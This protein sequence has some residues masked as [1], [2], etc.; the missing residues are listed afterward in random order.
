MSRICLLC[1]IAFGLSV[2]PAWAAKT[3]VVVL[4]NGDRITGEVKELAY[5]QL[6]FKTDDIGTLYIEWNKIAALTTTQLLQVELAD[7]RRMFG[8]APEAG[9]APAALRLRSSTASGAAPRAPTDVKMSDIVRIA[10]LEQGVW[11]QRLD[12]SAS[13]GYSFTQANAIQVFN[14]AADVGSRDRKRRWNVALGAQVS[15]QTVGPTSE[16]ASLVSTL[17]RFMRD[18]YYYEGSLEFTRNRELGLDVRTLVGGTVGRYLLQNPGRE[19]RAG[20]GLAASTE[21]GADGNRRE[22][23]EAQFSSALR[24]FR[25]D[26]PETNVVASLALLP[27]L[28]ESGRVRGEGSLRLRRELVSDLFF[29]ILVYDSY[30]SRPSEGSEKNDW[31]LSTSLGYTF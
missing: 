26:S 25:F 18:R 17:E 15:S 23:L 13:L 6:K 10:T 5:G 11:Y 8:E 16:R 12:A 29:E 7:G 1:L 27:S 30:D 14:V 24:L 20:A 3:D 21:L 19:W 22:N 4:L 31:G 2:A 9:A 28:T